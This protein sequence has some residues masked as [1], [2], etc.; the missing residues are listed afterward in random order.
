MDVSL[1][2][3]IGRSRHARSIRDCE[4]GVD[5][6]LRPEHT[7]A[8]RFL[9]HLRHWCIL[10]RDAEAVTSLVVSW[11]DRRKRRL[12]LLNRAQRLE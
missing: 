4:M 5:G 11:V 9:G 6:Y 7:G 8:G 1:I 3:L 2:D 10:A 12:E